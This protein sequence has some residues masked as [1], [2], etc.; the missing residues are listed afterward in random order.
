MVGLGP[1]LPG[2]I[3]TMGCW[4]V[5]AGSSGGTASPAR[6][7]CLSQLRCPSGTKARL[8]PRPLK[9]SGREAHRDLPHCPNLR[10][11]HA[12]TC[13]WYLWHH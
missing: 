13:R 8:Q 10:Q 12:K 7:R 9:A 4:G 1:V 6:P 2:S 3:P 5:S 11:P